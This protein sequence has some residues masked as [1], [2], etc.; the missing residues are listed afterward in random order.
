MLEDVPEVL[1][2]V[3]LVTFCVEFHSAEGVFISVW[4]GANGGYNMCQ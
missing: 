4:M 1:T 2:H 3:V